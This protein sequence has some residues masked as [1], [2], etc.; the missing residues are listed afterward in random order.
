MPPFHVEVN[1]LVEAKLL[2]NVLADY[3]SFQ[4]KNRVRSDYCNAGGLEVYEPDLQDWFE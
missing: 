3:D 2:L 4:Y 1:N